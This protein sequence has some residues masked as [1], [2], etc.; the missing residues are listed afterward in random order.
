MKDRDE[1]N[2]RDSF[3]ISSTIHLRSSSQPTPLVASSMSPKTNNPLDSLTFENILRSAAFQQNRSR[4]KISLSLF[5]WVLKFFKSRKY[6]FKIYIRINFIDITGTTPL[7]PVVP[8]LPFI[9]RKLTHIPNI[10]TVDTLPSPHSIGPGAASESVR[11]PNFEQ[12]M[13]LHHA[14]QQ[15]KIIQQN[16]QR[17]DELRYDGT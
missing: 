17:Q 8:P 3:P 16:A 4:G 1:V 5:L 2:L 13:I 9:D 7:S 6:I 12:L 10:T 14:Q 15:H 11:P